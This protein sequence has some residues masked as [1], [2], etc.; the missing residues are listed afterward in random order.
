MKNMKN[1]KILM[2][3]IA[4]IAK[5]LVLG[6]LVAMTCSCEDFLTISPTDRIVE[7]DFWKSKEDVE[8]VANESYRL[9]ARWNFLSRVLVW[10]ELRSDNVIEGNYGGDNDIK[11]IMEANLLPT[12]GYTSW[13]EFYRIIN[14]C[15]LVLKYAEGVLDEDPDFTE[16]DKEVI[17][18]EMLAVR[19]LCHF[20]LVRTFRDIPLLLEAKVK[21]S[22]NLYQFQVEPIEALDS[23]LSDLYKAENMVLTS[24]NYGTDVAKNK[25]RITKDAVRA[26]IADV[27]LWKAAFI[28]YEAKGDDTG[29]Q[30][31]YD[32]CIE[33]CD[34]VL[35]TRMKYIENYAVKNKTM[36]NNVTLHD[37]YPLIFP[38]EN[39]GYALKDRLPYQPYVWSFINCNNICESIFEIQHETN[40]GTGNYEVPYFYGYSTDKKSFTVG[41]LSASRYLAELKEGLYPRGDFR[42]V[43]YI[44]TDSKDKYGIIKYGYSAL[45]ENREKIDDTKIESYNIFGNPEPT[46]LECNTSDDNS[47]NKGKRYFDGHRRNWSMYRI[48][49][50]ML[51]KAEALALRK[52]NKQDE[53]EAYALVEAIYNRSQMGYEK[54][55]KSIGRPDY[56]VNKIDLA[57]SQKTLL[58]LIF[59]ERQREF[60]FE[61]KRWFDLVRNALRN[62]STEEI[63]EVLKAKYDT[64]AAQYTAKMEEIDALFF[65]IAESEINASVTSDT[66]YLKQNWVYETTD[67]MQTN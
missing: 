55:G 14:N 3:R 40:V 18:G 37:T 62:N 13:A 2:S 58:Q 41:A 43:S 19:A 31:C 63:L 52:A 25:G 50:I 56:E 12:N 35:D 51:I 67:D 5:T 65:P 22:D 15:N 33:Y 21:D 44:Q 57:T 47:Y 24:G 9:M 26:M 23:C 49:D 11:N 34:L 32:K 42:R 46:Y 66:V 7:D 53:E 28:S 64:N 16:G 36:F 1:N 17:C 54:E 6:S 4:H 61:G 8:N 59:D 48:S 38:E 20:Y 29:A 39:N 10:G 30:A 60:A 45:K 27:L